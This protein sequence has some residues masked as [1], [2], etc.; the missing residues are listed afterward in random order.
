MGADDM[1]SESV[2]SAVDVDGVWTIGNQGVETF[3]GSGS[4]RPPAN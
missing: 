2:E 3:H 1:D 4:K